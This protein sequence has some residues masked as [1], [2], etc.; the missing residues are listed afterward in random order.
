MN[1]LH[2][3]NYKKNNVFLTFTLIILE[4]FY[5]DN[6]F[7]KIPI[8]HKF[9]NQKLKRFCDETSLMT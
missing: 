9:F 5:F 6:N 4:L 7:K 2:D 1:F 8:K 3:G